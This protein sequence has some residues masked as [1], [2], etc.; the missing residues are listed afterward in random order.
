[1]T[2]LH[3][4]QAK[5]DVFMTNK[6]IIIRRTIFARQLAHII[7]EMASGNVAGFCTASK[8]SRGS[9]K[10]WL[11]QKSLPKTDNLQKLL[12][13]TCQPRD[14]FFPQIK[15]GVDLADQEI[16]GVIHGPKWYH[17]ALDK[18]FAS[19]ETSTIRAIKANIEEFLEKIEDKKKQDKKIANLEHQ[20]A[21]VL[22]K[23]GKSDAAHTE[24]IGDAAT[25]D[26]APAAGKPIISEF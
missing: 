16:V 4:C 12:D 2:Y 13:Y 8:L 25:Q 21:I 22:K 19:K 24:D 23:D 3:Q 10:Q 6:K 7:N 14:F 26:V 11:E 15:E 20:M 17:Q 9:V 5:N 1:M 18:I